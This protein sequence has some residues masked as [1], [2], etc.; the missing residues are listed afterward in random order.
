MI[1]ISNPKPVLC[2][3]QRMSRYVVLQVELRNET[4]Y[5]L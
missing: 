1:K 5:R 4:Q 3:S 2:Y